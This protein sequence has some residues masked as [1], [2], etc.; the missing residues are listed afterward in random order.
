MSRTSRH[1]A[2]PFRLML[3]ALTVVLGALI[4]GPV[5]SAAA[6]T[7][8]IN[9]D[10][11][12]GGS[13]SIEATDL[14]SL[15]YTVTVVDDATWGS[16]TA[17]QFGSYDLLV[18]GDPTCST[19]PPGLIA[20]APVH[21]SV[22]LGHAGGRTMAGNRIVIGTD[23]VFHAT[24]GGRPDAKV[25]I[26]DGL[27][28]AGLQSGTT[29]MYFD[30]S[31]SGEEG[32]AAADV[33]IAT[34]LSEGSGTWTIDDSPPCGGNVSLI[35]SNPAFSDLTTADL[36]GWGCSVHESFPTFTSDFSALAVATD[37]PSHPTCGTDPNTGTNA[38]GEAYVLIAGSGIVVTSGEISLTPTTATNPVNTDHT[39]TAHVTQ[40]GTPASGF[41]VTF[42]VTGQNAGATGTC[43]PA[44]CVSDANGNVTFTYHDSNGAGTDT[45][46]A[47]FT[48]ASGSLQSATASK[49]WSS[50]DTTAPT[51]KLTATIAGPPKQIQ[52]TVQDTGSGLGSVVVTKS[53]NAVTT[54]PP[55]TSGTNS[56]VVV[57]STK[58]NQTLGSSVALKVT[59]VAGNVTLCDPALISLSHNWAKKKFQKVR[60]GHLA[61]SESK[62]DIVNGWFGVRHVQIA[63][64]GRV[65][66]SI[67]M[68]NGQ[69]RTLNVAKAM[70]PG[71]KNTITL[72]LAGRTGGSATV[73]IHD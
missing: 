57:T 17:A 55:F 28:F 51:C 53:T 59:D 15:G 4:A 48:D 47:S 58:T 56:A 27:K 34:A 18:A 16:M 62:I 64:N 67:T 19:L 23:P 26:M 37:T 31:C 60:I 11:V 33:A 32:Q 30:A 8:L 72:I 3:I 24:V 14:T 6:K 12:T 1:T 69:T 38:C 43:V 54:V 7:A 21:G 52:I 66:R 5:A 25:L 50:G 61:Q 41:L 22:V 29:G 70:R 45:I 65:V 35:A 10:T 71:N 63:V 49:T 68:R 73:A 20:S 40:G 13:S 44:S 46:K 36:E 42:S 9:G 39:V 2:R